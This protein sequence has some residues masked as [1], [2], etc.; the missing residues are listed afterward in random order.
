MTEF[1]FE[2]NKLIDTIWT[3]TK[4]MYKNDGNKTNEEVFWD[5]FKTVYGDESVQQKSEFDKFYINEF[6]Q[7]KHC[8][9]ENILAK[10]IINFVNLSLVII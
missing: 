10:D 8:C 5:Y 1:G 7:L 3:G 9:K 4:C 2:P 6:K